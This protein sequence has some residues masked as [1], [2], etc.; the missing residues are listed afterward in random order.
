MF[1]ENQFIGYEAGR[2]KLRTPKRSILI[3]NTE[4]K[5]QTL[6]VLN[7]CSSSQSIKRSKSE[8]RFEGDKSPLSETKS[9]KVTPTNRQT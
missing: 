2:R 9:K 8:E 3:T 1:K 5:R 7:T 4:D 6:P